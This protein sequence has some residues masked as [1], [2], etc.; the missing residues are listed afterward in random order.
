MADPREQILARLV[1]IGAGLDG[2]KTA[3]RNATE[4]PETL[5]P[6]FVVHDG[7]ESGDDSDPTS[8]RPMS[9]ISPR[10]VTMTPEI[11]ICVP[12]SAANVGTL[13]NQLRARAI[14]AIAA[15][16]TLQ[17]MTMNAEGAR[18]EGAVTGLSRARSML[19]DAGLSFSFRYLLYP[20]SI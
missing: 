12:A 1:E 18:Y 16:A 8:R 2:I 4:L 14:N 9:P 6:A 10:I 15:D 17:G 19:G 5:L 13:V 7:D 20:G 11:Y 3:R